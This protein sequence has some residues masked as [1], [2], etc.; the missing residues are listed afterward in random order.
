MSHVKLPYT[1]SMHNRWPCFIYKILSLCLALLARVIR[2]P[3]ISRSTRTSECYSRNHKIWQTSYMSQGHR[4]LT[5]LSCRT[6][7]ARTKN[8][9]SKTRLNGLLE[10]P[11][12]C[13][14]HKK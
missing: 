11:L 2:E 14:N 12:E 9:C 8:K 1:T 4:F 13:W 5:T 10:K 6:L 3:L 7:R